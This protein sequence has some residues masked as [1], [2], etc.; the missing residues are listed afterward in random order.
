MFLCYVLDLSWQRKIDSLYININRNKIP[1][2][3]MSKQ[4]TLKHINNDNNDFGDTVRRN[5]L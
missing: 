1:K 2:F 4:Q 5:L 3:D